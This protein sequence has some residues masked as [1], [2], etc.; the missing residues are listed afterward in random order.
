MRAAAAL[1]GSF[2]LLA[3]VG[4]TKADPSAGQPFETQGVVQET[5][6]V[7]AAV[8]QSQQFEENIR[9]PLE[10]RLVVY[11]GSQVSDLTV[12]SI[13]VA[14]DGT[15]MVR[16]QFDAAKSGAL[17]PDKL[18][19]MQIRSAEA[20][21]H[22]IHV[23]YIVRHAGD[24]DNATPTRID[25]DGVLLKKSGLSDIEVSLQT[26]GLFAA[27][28]VKLIQWKQRP[29]QSS[30]GWSVFSLFKGSDGGDD[31]SFAPGDS[32]DPLL[33][34]AD[35]L[36]SA[37]QGIEGAM[38]LLEYQY[39]NAAQPLAPDFFYSLSDA[40]LSVGDL[41]GAAAA[42]RRA[43][44]DKSNTPSIVK[45]R[46]RLADAYYKRGDYDQASAQLADAPPRLSKQQ[47][48]EWRD[49]QSRV[50]LAQRR[51]SDAGNVLQRLDINADFESYV[52]YYNLGVA[53][54]KDGRTGQG[55]TI[56]DRIG[57]IAS[58]N[59]SLKALSD[60]ANLVLGVHF[61]QA[62]Q[63][64]T[65]IPILGRVR[66]R[67]P[68]SNSA[69]LNL[70]W[71][72]LAPPGT[73][74]EKVQIGDERT[75]GPPPES[76]IGG[77]PSLTDHNLYQRYH[78]G[79]FEK[80]KMGANEDARFK[81][82]LAIWAELIDRDQD[83]LVV[84]QGLISV[85]FALNRFGAYQE[86]AKYYDRAVDALEHARL[87][88]EKEKA[89]LQSDRW[90]YEVLGSEQLAQSEPGSVLKRLPSDALTL[91]ILDVLAGN[92]FQNG[93][94]A[95]REILFLKE[96]LEERERR[97]RDLNAPMP[98]ANP[99]DIHIDQAE[100]DRLLGRIA[101]LRSELAS[102]QTAQ[103]E[104]LRKMV[105]ADLNDQENLNE[106]VLASVRHEIAAA[107]DRRALK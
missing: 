31:A 107:N 59:E 86:S 71:A 28:E 62:Q 52:R 105:I 26:S 37:G 57:S 14:L 9:Y 53:L 20:G 90:I 94:W 72:W 67:G 76:S 65:A 41:Q 16:R 40:L 64:A 73:Q 60:K 92:Q 93:L 63:G 21:Q 104:L 81:K 54:I 10:S 74:N 50:L 6:A 38:L 85:A 36:E 33:R 18:C 51:F 48:F 12:L 99:A 11:A 27:P 45:I 61:L 30:S 23:E 96:A 22:Q 1:I 42:Y 78:L 29:L 69:L 103:G 43:G 46:L 80:A 102:L 95:Y 97:L 3:T 75:V 2:A 56:L 68:F 39:E 15:P 35:F 8:G 77:H 89:Y 58:S 82:A 5:N 13:G 25:Y 17:L 34:N 84:Q 44:T 4:P 98:G 19:R 24:P 49:L 106:K 7:L 55:A 88:F 91:H 100:L 66:L 83:D 79:A 87:G 47:S 32:A 70:G 101:A